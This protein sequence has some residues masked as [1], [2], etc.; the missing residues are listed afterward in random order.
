MVAAAQQIESIASVIVDSVIA[1]GAPTSTEVAT[2]KGANRIA[3]EQGLAT[4]CSCR[5]PQ[6][7]STVTSTF[8]LPNAVVSAELPGLAIHTDEIDYNCG[9]EGFANCSSN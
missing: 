2:S 8:T 3:A 7:T 5:L 6:P 4:A 9:C 1:S